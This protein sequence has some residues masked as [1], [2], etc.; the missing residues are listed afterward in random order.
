MT[1]DIISAI[2]LESTSVSIPL[3]ML[4]TCIIGIIGTTACAVWQW[5]SI[6][7]KLAE[8]SDELRDGWTVADEREMCHQMQM[9]NPTMIVPDVI[10]VRRA[11]REESRGN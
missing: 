2:P 4:W 10:H 1:P 8:I 9:K 11:V 3:P 7:T 6:N 5:T